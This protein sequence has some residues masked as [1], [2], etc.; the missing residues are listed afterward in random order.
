[1]LEKNKF[2]S[3]GDLVEY[4]IDNEDKI[5]VKEAKDDDDDV[6]TEK[7]EKSLR[8]ET[9]ILYKQ[10]VCLVCF[11]A[12][13]S[14]V[15]LPCCHLTHCEKCEKTLRWCPYHACQ[16]EIHSTIQTYVI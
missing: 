3:A 10:S 1:M 15:C 4:L 9:E 7:K 16:E 12:K 5:I 8:E 2:E 13:R 14:R 11:Q 6:T